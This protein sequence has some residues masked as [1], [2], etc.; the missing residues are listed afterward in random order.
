MRDRPQGLELE[1][2]AGRARRGDPTL[3]L[4][5][6]ARYRDA[7]VKRAE[8]IAARQGETGDG[9]ERRERDALARLLEQDGDLAAL[10]RALAAA[11]R[12]GRFDPGAPATT[13]CYRHLWETALERVRESNPKALIALRLE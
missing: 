4:P 9:P 12:G 1:D 6:D 11:I 13:A 5:D 7:M 10:N 8:T 3:S 2:L